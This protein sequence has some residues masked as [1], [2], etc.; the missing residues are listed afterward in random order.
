MTGPYDAL[1]QAH[2]YGVGAAQAGL[3]DPGLGALRLTGPAVAVLAEAAVTSA[4]PFVRAPLLGRISGALLLH[5]AAGDAA[6]HCPSCRVP[7]PCPT[8]GVLRGQSAP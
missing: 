5:P 6:G 8:A 7:A 1:E 4:T 2:R 3:R